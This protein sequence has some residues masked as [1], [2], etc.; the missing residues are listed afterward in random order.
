MSLFRPRVTAPLFFLQEE[1]HLLFFP[2]PFL[3]L[4]LIISLPDEVL[5]FVSEGRL[6]LFS[7]WR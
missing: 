3:A 5:P 2:F 1:V 4:G 6:P 7:F